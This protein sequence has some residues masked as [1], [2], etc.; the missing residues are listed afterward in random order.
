M[1]KGFVTDKVVVGD[2]TIN[3]VTGGS[4]PA[5]LLLHGYPQCHVTWHAVAALLEDDFSMVIPDLRGYGES[6]GP[7]PDP[8]HKNYS[9]RTMAADMVAL[10][11]H[12]GHETFHL[13][14]HDR[15]ARVACRLTLDH[16]DRV[17][18]LVS[19]DTA[20]TLD[21]WD[22]LNGVASV[23]VFHWPFLA[24]PAPFPERLIGN[25]P[26]YFLNYLLDN[27]VG[28]PDGLSEETRALYIEHFRKPSVIEA[29]SEDY[30]AGATIDLQH[31]EE[32]REAGK[33]ITC[34]VL[35]PWGSRYISESPIGIWHKWA[36]NVQDLRI[37]CGHFISEEEPEICANAIR[38]FLK[39]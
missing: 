31:D 15:G 38:T 5:V 30:R 4:G 11:K 19:L 34:P 14:G 6:I 22:T 25:D 7:G 17:S 13:V 32:D 3:V 35:V 27:W 18:R 23:D 2:A 26:D 12:F 20:P 21:T 29:M 28:R 39:E 16:P 1:F 10:M 36:D 37:D 8:A 9:K 33:R 24:Q